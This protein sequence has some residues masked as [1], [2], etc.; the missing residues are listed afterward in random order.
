M[1]WLALLATLLLALAPAASRALA[2]GGPPA[3]GWV[4]LCTREGLQWLPARG[5]L[6]EDPAQP[7]AT[8][9][10]DCDYCPLAGGTPP[11]PRVVAGLAPLPPAHRPVPPP[12]AVVPHLFRGLSGLGSR[13]PPAYA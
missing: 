1:A 7:A 9:H 6:P 5:P 4:Q 2:A 10:Q 12:P 3:D 8:P 11:P 13:G